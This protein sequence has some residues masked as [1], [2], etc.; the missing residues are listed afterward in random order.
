MPHPLGV[1]SSDPDY[2]LRMLAA[3]RDQLY[4]CFG[5]WADTLFELVD[6]L[7]GTTRPIRSV[8]EL[9]FEPVLRRGWGSL[10]QALQ[11]GVVDMA[12]AA[13]VKIFEARCSEI[14]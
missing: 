13:R 5:R 7:A 6:A 12:A 11:H 14:H 4:R 2:D 10:Y 9:M 1:V 8:A 3:F